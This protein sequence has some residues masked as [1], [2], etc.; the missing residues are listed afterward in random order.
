[1]Q[2]NT[3]FLGVVLLSLIMIPVIVVLILDLFRK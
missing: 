2:I 3:G 1:M